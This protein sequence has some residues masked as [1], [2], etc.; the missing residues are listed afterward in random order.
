MNQI[1][2]EQIKCM[3]LSKDL[4]NRNLLKSGHELK[5]EIF[6]Y[7]NELIIL[8]TNDKEKVDETKGKN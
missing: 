1:E 8:L 7:I 6:N 5:K 2:K 3:L 4:K